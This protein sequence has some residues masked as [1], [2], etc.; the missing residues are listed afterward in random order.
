MKTTV[1]LGGFV[2]E[3]FEV[4]EEMNFGGAQE[5]K[6]HRFVGG[7]KKIDSMGADED[8]VEWRGRFRGPQA[9][10]RARA[11]DAMRK[12][13]KAHRLTWGE[14]AFTVKIARF[15]A[16]YQNA[17]EIPYRIVCEVETDDASPI[18]TGGQIGAT[19]MIGGD[20][21]DAFAAASGI[22]SRELTGRLGGIRDAI[23]KVQDFGTA[24]RETLNSVLRPIISAQ[25]TVTALITAAEDTLES[26]QAV[27]GIVPGLANRD[28]TGGLLGQAA[29]AGDVAA[30]YDVQAFLGRAETNLGAIGSSGAEV[31]TAGADLFSLAAKHYGDA[32][33]WATIAR[34]NGL[35]D[36]IQE[37]I[38][39]VTI[40]PSPA[41]TG[42]V[43]K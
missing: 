2:F 20:F 25:Q 9:M 24:S 16:D 7:R 33:E 1:S 17:R 12:A 42:G 22:G 4:P 29:A 6:V 26:V 10:T 36:P 5:L 39:A 14:L 3:D 30:L 40:P 34:A 41:N 32:T 27:G 38:Q 11:L 15:A 28:L 43:L 18:T 21:R 37:G 19:Q 31:V 8:P 13:G 23:S 35:I